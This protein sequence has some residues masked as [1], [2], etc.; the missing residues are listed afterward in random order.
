[1]HL[2]SKRKR[3]IIKV[4]FS[5]GSL[6]ICRLA[7]EEDIANQHLLQWETHTIKRH[8]FCFRDRRF[9]ISSARRQ[10]DTGRQFRKLAFQGRTQSDTEM[11][12]TEKLY[13]KH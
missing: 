6:L 5:P 9:D 10:E 8:P 12:A 7:D 2:F 13:Y 11:N 3:K 1:M 4:T